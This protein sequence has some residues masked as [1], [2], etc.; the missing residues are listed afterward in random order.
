MSF[1]A[2]VLR[3][4]MYDDVRILPMASVVEGAFAD[5]GHEARLDLVLGPDLSQVGMN[6]PRRLDRSHPS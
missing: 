4:N 1:D 6:R 2:P 3:H 5:Q